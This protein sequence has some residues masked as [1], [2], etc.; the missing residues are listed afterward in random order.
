MGATRVG[1]GLAGLA[2]GGLLVGGVS[3]ATAALSSTDQASFCVKKEGAMRME[4]ADKPCTKDETQLLLATAGGLNR[5]ETALDLETTAR[6]NGDSALSS[7][8]GVLT[9]G[10][11]QE[12][13][14]RG[15]LD[16]RLTAALGTETSA[17][18]GGDSFL[19][20]QVT[21]L[22]MKHIQDNRL[23]GELTN[24]V[25]TLEGVLGDMRN[26][27]L[28]TSSIA[29]DNKD[30]LGRLTTALATETSARI[31]GD[32]FLQGQVT[33]LEMKHIQNSGLIRELNTAVFGATSP[34]VE[35]LRETVTSQ[36]AGLYGLTSRVTALEG[37][38]PVA[39]EGG[40]TFVSVWGDRVSISYEGPTGT[41][42]HI[43]GVECAVGA[44][45]VSGMWH[46]GD[47]MDV[48]SSQRV[49]L[50]GWNGG[51]GVSGWQIT[52]Q[53]LAFPAGASYAQ[54]GVVCWQPPA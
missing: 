14:D 34:L 46:I 17:R 42:Y 32:S 2:I 8:T 26:Q 29:T 1:V 22:Q 19:Q 12:M 39:T 18:T 15:A 23:I 54:V 45:A 49:N 20:G 43:Y 38:A 35:G 41:N 27:L 51:S 36:G 21:S 28:A 30:S 25:A 44:F 13:L 47:G 50:S 11:A 48:K 3:L 5:V 9:T 10:L 31:G 53:R 16:T 52:A 24:R 7:R 37:G 33:S 6:T 4:T 40:G